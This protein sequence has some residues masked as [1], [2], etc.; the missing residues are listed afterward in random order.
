MRKYSS[1]RRVRASTVDVIGCTPVIRRG[2]REWTKAAAV[3][4]GWTMGY[5]ALNDAGASPQD[6]VTSRNLYVTLLTNLGQCRT[7]SHLS[8]RHRTQVPN[9]THL[10]QSQSVLLFYVYVLVQLCSVIV[11][12]LFLVSDYC[13][14][15]SFKNTP[16]VSYCV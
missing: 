12:L 2:F 8:H 10:F 5:G 11:P 6:S 16:H 9:N 14:V 4:E 7:L 15:K 3:A 1:S 13:L